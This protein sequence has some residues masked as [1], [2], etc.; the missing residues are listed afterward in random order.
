MLRTKEAPWLRYDSI[1]RA[2]EIN[3]RVNRV[4]RGLGRRSRICICLPFITFAFIFK[5][6]LRMDYV[7]L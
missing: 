1:T 3:R 4:N 6:I 5:I 2:V 7:R